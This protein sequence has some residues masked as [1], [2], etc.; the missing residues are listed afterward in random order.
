MS[1]QTNLIT[2]KHQIANN[3]L[4]NDRDPA[5]IELILVSKARTVDDIKIA[6]Q[7]GHKDFG[8]NYLQEALEKIVAL[9]ENEIVWHFI[10]AIQN[11]KTKLIAENFDWVHSIDQLKTIE[12]LAA[13]RPAHLSP[14]N[15][16][17]QVNIDDEQNK[18]G[19]SPAAV[20]DLAQ[21]VLAHPAQLRLR[22]LMAIPK[23]N[24]DE[25]GT[26]KSFM[27]MQELYLQ[28]KS[29]GLPLDTL[30]MGMSQDFQLAIEYGATLLRIGTAIFGQR[31]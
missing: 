23:S 31:N 25:A 26:R 8:E 5:T 28:L 4:A 7:I 29:Q 16:C 19:V 15:V 22:G 24:Q 2:L 1:I 11:N 3:A 18:G 10:G 6:L 27:T 17:I 9:K 12:R 13:Q 14:L 20:M 21:A 30:S